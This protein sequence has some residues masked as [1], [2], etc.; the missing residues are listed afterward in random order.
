MIDPEYSSL[1]KL[2]KKLFKI[3]IKSDKTNN[4]LSLIV[5]QIKSKYEPRTEFTKWRKSQEGKLWKKQ[6]HQKQK[7]SCAMCNQRIELKGSHIDHI[8]PLAKHPNLSLDISNLQITCW[9]CNTYK[10]DQ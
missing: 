5:N 7:E 1:E 3:N 6:Q 2:T 8:K 4:K 9:Q 10:G